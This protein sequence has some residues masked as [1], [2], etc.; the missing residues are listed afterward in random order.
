[1]VEFSISNARYNYVHDQKYPS[2]DVDIHHIVLKR[3]GAKYYF[4]YALVLLVL[5]CGF[6]LYVFEVCLQTKFLC[7]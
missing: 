3:S 4:V 5:A 6:Y 1:M 2:E 7:Q